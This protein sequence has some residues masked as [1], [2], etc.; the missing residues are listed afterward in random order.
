ML[1]ECPFQ[2]KFPSALKKD[3]EYFMSLAYNQAIKAWEHDETPIGAVAVLGDEVIAS[4]YNAVIK[5]NDPTAHAE[6]Q[7][8]TQAAKVL[9]DWRLSDVK[10]YVTKEP[11]PMCSGAMIVGRVGAVIFGARDAKMGCLGGCCDIS[12]IDG[13]NHRP[14]IKSGVL[15][16][17][18]LQ[19]LQ[20]F[21][22]LKRQKKL[23]N[24]T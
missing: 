24:Y 8:L 23:M 4:A 1:I 19:I 5:M 22:Q 21:F 18:C 17:D 7:V 6:M 16:A 2:K 3:D 13:M 11:C 14:I 10:L 12:K 15:E 9:G 20:K